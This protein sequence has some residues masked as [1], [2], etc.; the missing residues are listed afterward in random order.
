MERGR[1]LQSTSLPSQHIPGQALFL[2]TSSPPLAQSQ[3]SSRQVS[4]SLKR[5]SAAFAP[6]DSLTHIFTGE[7]C[8][9]APPQVPKNNS[10]WEIS[11]KCA[12]WLAQLE[13]LRVAFT[14]CSART[15]VGLLQTPRF[16]PTAQKH[17]HE[18]RVCVC[19][20]IDC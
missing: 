9:F 1:A 3:G 12:R 13:S 17:A 14:L 7:I 18:W 19:P 5:Q 16:T 4:L 15:C 10:I 11:L 8:P 2:N 20:G 6:H